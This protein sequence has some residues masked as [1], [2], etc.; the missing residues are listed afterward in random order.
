MPIYDFYCNG[1]DKAFSVFV[2]MTEKVESCTL[3]SSKD[4]TREIED[5][6]LSLREE[7]FANRVGDIVKSHIEES[8]KDLKKEK[9]T[10]KKEVL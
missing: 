9:E 3:C 7:N 8:K 2:S 1:C 6:S 4:I 5:L 10:L